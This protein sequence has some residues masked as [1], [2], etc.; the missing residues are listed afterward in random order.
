MACLSWKPA[1]TKGFTIMA[2]PIY[3]LEALPDTMLGSIEFEI[4]SS[5][6]ELLVAHEGTPQF[7]YMNDRMGVFAARLSKLVPVTSTHPG[8]ASL[9][10]EPIL[11]GRLEMIAT[12]DVSTQ[13][14]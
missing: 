10:D 13:P 2:N 14:Q 9:R 6:A 1:G 12:H 7:F 4:L 11:R 8:L 3:L 5:D